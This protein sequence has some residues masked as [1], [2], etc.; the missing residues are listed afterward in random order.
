MTHDAVRVL[1]FKINPKFNIGII[2][3]YFSDFM[4]F[5]GCDYCHPGQIIHV[6]LSQ[7]TENA[8]PGVG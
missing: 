2:T 5:S 4:T 1:N 8:V 6:C 3:P 7:A